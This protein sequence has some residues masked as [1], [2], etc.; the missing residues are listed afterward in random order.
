[1]SIYLPSRENTLVGAYGELCPG[2]KEEYTKARTRGKRVRQKP[3][4][5]NPAHG[6]AVE[7]L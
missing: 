5:E 2:Q 7:T 6:R 1:M 4:K 3:T